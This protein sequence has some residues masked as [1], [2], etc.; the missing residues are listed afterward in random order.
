MKIFTVSDL[1]LPGGMDKTMD[2]FG[3]GWQGHWDKIRADWQKR[4]KQDDIVLIAGDISWAMQLD[5][6]IG[7]LNAIGALPGKKYSSG[8][9]MTIGGAA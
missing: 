3:S 9:I 5:D 6:A 1:H 4:V 2:M 8:A 7:D